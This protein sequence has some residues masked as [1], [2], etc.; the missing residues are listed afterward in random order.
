MDQSDH[1]EKTNQLRLISGVQSNVMIVVAVGSE[2]SIHIPGNFWFHEPLNSWRSK[3]VFLPC[4]A[5][6]KAILLRWS[7]QQGTESTLIAPHVVFS[8]KPD[9]E[10]LQITDGIIR[11][12]EGELEF[13]CHVTKEVTPKSNILYQALSQNQAFAEAC[14]GVDSI[15]NYLDWFRKRFFNEQDIPTSYKF[16][17]AK[18]KHCSLERPNQ[19]GLLGALVLLFQNAAHIK[20]TKEEAIAKEVSNKFIADCFHKA[21]V[22]AIANA[23]AIA[24][25]KGAGKEADKSAGNGADKEASKQAGMQTGKGCANP[26][27]EDWES[28]HKE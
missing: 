22:D 8:Y 19:L 3:T 26:G 24:A 18:F 13:M 20:F 23:N 11:A 4:R 1:R 16:A 27:L 5:L 28:Y 15:E 10:L 2:D 9:S 25:V 14:R 17:T 21:K 7:E 12:R 6:S